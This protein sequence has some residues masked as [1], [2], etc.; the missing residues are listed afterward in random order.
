MSI[1]FCIAAKVQRQQKSVIIMDMSHTL[2]LWLAERCG[3]SA[4][5]LL[6]V[7][8]ETIFAALTS[9]EQ[10]ARKANFV[11]VN[12]GVVAELLYQAEPDL[13][14]T[15]LRRL[16]LIIRGSKAVFLVVTAPYDNDPFDPANY[17][18]GFPL[19]ELAAIRLW[20]REESWSHKDGLPTAYKANLAIVKNEL[21]TPGKGA[22]IRIKLE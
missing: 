16:Q 12:L 19:D 18:P 20:I 8:P 7:R 13:L 10:A 22:I 21:A 5:Q 6:L 17:P 15:L 4:P 3:L 2:D 9:L 1:A 11:I 14:L